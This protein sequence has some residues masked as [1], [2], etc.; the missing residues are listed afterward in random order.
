MKRGAVV[1]VLAVVAGVLMVPSAQ[2]NRYT[3]PNYIID[4]GNIGASIAA[5]TEGGSYRMV[6]SGGESIVGSGQG[7]SYK[8][9]EGYVAQ[10]PHSLELNVS[11]P[12]ITI[13]PVIPGISQTGQVDLEVISTTPEY[14]IAI[15]QLGD[16]TSGS[17]TI[18]AISGGT[19]ASPITWN[20]G[21]TKGLGMTLASVSFG[22]L[23]AKWSGGNAYAA[24]PST[25]TGLYARTGLGEDGGID[26][27]TV[28]YRLDATP[29]QE[30][31]EYTTT[32]TYTAT[33]MP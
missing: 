16:L 26:T 30:A 24:L 6:A 19:I 25:A 22:T 18:P 14:A 13:P 1:A 15:H 32:V 12:E 28:R 31:G 21:T 9:D 4:A 29:Q 20:E 11:T 8:L 33:W 27:S 2:A 7:G 23:P 10:L 5:I 3:S 17:Y